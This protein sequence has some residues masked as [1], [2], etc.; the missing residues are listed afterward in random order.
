MR[1]VST[2]QARKNIKALVELVKD[3][4]DVVAIGRHNQVE[5]L[6]IKYPRNYNKK[7]SGITNMNANSDSFRFLEDEP[8]LY[9]VDDLKRRYA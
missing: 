5:A 1:T 9:T 7:F 8:D 4:G 3:T 6:L 2:T